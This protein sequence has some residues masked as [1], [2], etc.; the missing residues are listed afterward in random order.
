MSEPAQVVTRPWATDPIRAW[1]DTPIP[2][3]PPMSEEQVAALADGALVLILWGGGNGPH[4]YEIERTESGTLWPIRPGS[5]G[6][7]GYRPQDPMWPSY[8]TSYGTE[9]WQSKVWPT[10]VHGSG[11]DDDG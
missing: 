2:D 8:L 5:R 3:D 10:S 11:T 4:V 1:F 7:H 9:R 6:R